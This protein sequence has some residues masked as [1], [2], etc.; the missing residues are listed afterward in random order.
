VH[1]MSYSVLFRQFPLDQLDALAPIVRQVYGIADFDARAKIRRGWG[2]LERHATA[3]EA[4]RVAGAVPGCIAIDDEQ[5]RQLAEPRPM[6]GLAFTETGIVPDGANEIAWND[7]AIVAAGGLAEEVVRRETTGKDAG[8]GKMAMGLGVFLVTGIPLGLF[9]GKKQETKPVKSNRWLTF[10]S[11]V[12]WQG[13]Q[14]AIALDHFSFS[15]LGEKKQLQAIVNFRVL[16]AE[17]QQRTSARLN[18]GARFVLAS[19][20]LSLA[21]YTS[22]SEYE[23]ELLWMFNTA[24]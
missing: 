23:S 7:V 9:G 24:P 21:N 1:A 22:L 14:F 13:E 12:T 4:Q 17:L 20:P 11:L 2:F 3:E 18:H 19:Q 15:G 5:L 16:I 10:G 8:I 6:T